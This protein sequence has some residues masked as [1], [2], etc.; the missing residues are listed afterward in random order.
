VAELVA[1]FNEAETTATTLTNYAVQSVTIGGSGV[2]VIASYIA[3]VH[4]ESGAE[5]EVFDMGKFGSNR[6]EL[7]N[8]YLCGLVETCMSSLETY[9]S[10][11]HEL[12]FT[13]EVSFMAHDP[14]SY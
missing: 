7:D 1:S 11:R 6:R 9:L 10:Q 13:L 14:L 4:K 12:P 8:A 3:F 5:I 2:F